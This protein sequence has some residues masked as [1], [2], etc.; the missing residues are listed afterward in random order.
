MLFDAILGRR[1]PLHVARLSPAGAELAVRADD[2][3]TISLPKRE[4]P[5]AMQVGDL[6]EAVVYL[7]GEERPCATLKPTL[8]LRDQV[9][10]LQV[11][12]TTRFGAFVEWG[13][14]KELLVPLDEQT[15]PLEVGDRAPIALGLDDTGRLVGTMRVRERLKA[16]GDFARDE[17]VE[18]E[19][20][21]EEPGIG[22]FVILERT[23]FGLLPASEPHRLRPGDAERFRVA[24]VLPD[25]KV[26]LSLRGLASDEIANDAARVLEILARPGAARVSDRSSPDELRARFG[27]SKKAFKRAI[28]SLLKRGAVD[29]DPQGFVV[30]RPPR[31]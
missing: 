25:G 23:R 26:E 18:G 9:A 31:P 24:R 8:V 19:A 17:W 29:L 7:D 6:V 12:G 15:R 27:L 2:P 20:W 14:P 16:G 21:R 5:E 22:L 3:L 28:G 4:V 10:F 11:T 1:V 30:V 13:P